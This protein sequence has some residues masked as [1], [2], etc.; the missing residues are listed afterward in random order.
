MLP[1]RPVYKLESTKLRTCSQSLFG[2][3]CWYFS[4]ESKII[5]QLFSTIMSSHWVMLIW[6]VQVR[7]NF[8]PGGPTSWK[9]RQSCRALGQFIMTLADLIIHQIF[10]VQRHPVT[11]HAGLL[12]QM[13]WGPQP[14]EVVEF[15]LKVAAFCWG[16]ELERP[17]FWDMRPHPNTNGTRYTVF[18]L[19]TFSPGLE[20]EGKKSVRSLSMRSAQ[21]ITFNCCGI[22]SALLSIADLIC[23][24]LLSA[25]P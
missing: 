7:A 2:A 12:V 8:P 21:A 22:I 17:S 6:I 3:T 23:M 24:E 16:Q 1:L 15:C 4:S 10:V 19:D 13:G 14:F 25:S 5:M 18:F 11:W 20:E 9:G